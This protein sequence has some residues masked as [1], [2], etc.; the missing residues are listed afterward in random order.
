MAEVSVGIAGVGICVPD[1]VLTNRD[2][3][4]MVD[5]S[6]EWIRE[7]TGI[8]E[9]RIAAPDQS[10]SDL[11]V[12]A[13]RRALA[14]A[15]VT[16]G[17]VD[18]IIVA[19]VTPDMVFPSTA[20][21]VQERLGCGPVGAFDLSAGC[22]G[23]LYGLVAGAQFIAAGTYRTVLVIGAETLSKI[24]NWEDRSTCVL[25][26]DGAGAVVLRPA[27]AGWGLLAACLG[28]DGAGGDLLKIP[29]GGSRLPASALTVEKKLHYIH[30][31]GR[32]VF[33][34]AV[35]ILSE[36]ASEVIRAAGLKQDQIDLFIPHQANIRIIKA[37][38]KRLEL[39]M[40]RVVV[41]VDRYGNTSSASVPLALDE[42][43]RS[44]RLADGDRV[45]M[46]AFGAGLSWAA[47]AVRW[48]S[49]A[50]RGTPEPT[51]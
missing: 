15:G 27:P 6:D 4:S 36:A 31:N 44:G 11:A 39:P 20:S 46:V 26:G 49:T 37:A 32:E 10:T 42:A 24:I 29:A 14:D 8:R 33:R 47:A 2:L 38:V 5:T 40:D 16:P 18:L 13:A 3:E 43:A 12:V 34:F 17:E 23:F 1:R 28:S 19:T 45:V 30:M 21:L 48:Y 9:R 25:F 22:T 51:G 50:S 35:R 41:N 7:R